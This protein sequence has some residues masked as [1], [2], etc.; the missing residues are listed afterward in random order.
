MPRLTCTWQ[1]LLQCWRLNAKCMQQ[2]SGDLMP[3]MRQISHRQRLLTSSWTAS[4]CILPQKMDKPY[5]GS[6]HALSRKDITPASTIEASYGICGCSLIQLVLIGGLAV[7]RC[8][9]RPQHCHH[10]CSTPFALYRPHN[11]R[12]AAADL[13]FLDTFCLSSSAGRILLS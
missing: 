2:S 11:R 4:C 13:A 3:P 7:S 8:S 12:Q 9:E 1:V 5:Q 10:S 6:Q